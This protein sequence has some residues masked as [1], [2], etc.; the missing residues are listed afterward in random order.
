MCSR[1][2][3]VV[4]TVFLYATFTS[5]I[6]AQDSTSADRRI[7]VSEG[8][9]YFGFDYRTLKNTSLAGC[10]RTCLSDS[11]CRA[12]TFNT[13]TKRC[14]LKS[15]FGELAT[16]Q[17]A[18]AGRVVASAKPATESDKPPALTFLS[19]YFLDEAARYRRLL[20]EFDV[21]RAKGAHGLW[22][23][24]AAALSEGDARRAARNYRHALKLESGVH[25]LWLDL[26][27]AVLSVKGKDY[28]KTARLLE[29]ATSAAINAYD[30]STSNGERARALAFL[31]N[32]LQRRQL[33]RSSLEAYKASLLLT[34]TA[35]VRAAYAKL[36]A[37][38]GF[39]MVDYSV[40]SDAA[41]PRVCLRFSED[42]QTPQYGFFDLPDRQ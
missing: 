16:R 42:L 40:D 7:V 9:D 22:K 31:A 30:I 8:A 26:A 11:G 41:S 10:K 20:R 28:S 36:H 39:R 27:Y 18:V 13:E 23:D 6:N 1:F 35:S 37:Q 17:N 12:F 21:D 29:E 2:M 4:A 32:A 33:Y 3:A 5:S 15:D 38:H 25:A 34:E 14:F 19:R 24:G